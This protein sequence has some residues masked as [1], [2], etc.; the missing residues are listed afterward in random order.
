[1][2]KQIKDLK[3]RLCENPE[4]RPIYI[5]MLNYFCNSKEA[6]KLALSRYENSCKGCEFF[7]EEKNELLRFEDNQIPEL[8][9]KMCNDCGCNISFKLRQ[10]IKKCSRWQK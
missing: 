9:N 8:S 4:L 10:S 3:T 2:L 5:G 7:I 6:N 1:M